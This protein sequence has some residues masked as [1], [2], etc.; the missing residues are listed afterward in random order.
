MRPAPIRVGP[1]VLLRAAMLGAVFGTATFAA[2]G[3]PAGRLGLVLTGLSLA[4]M[5]PTL[6]ARTPARLGAGAA[7]HAVG[8]QV[9]AATLGGAALPA[10]VGF[11]IARS[12]VNAIGPLVTVMAG[13]AL[14]AHE[15]LL[16]ATRR[17]SAGGRPGRV[18][19]AS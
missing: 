9:S 13:A 8:F 6:M 15:A 12:G 7:A 4:P 3:G 1:D 5:Y 18:P 11:V 17:V 10:A 19:G 14:L 2:S 16:A